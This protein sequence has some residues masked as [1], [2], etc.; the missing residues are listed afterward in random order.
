MVPKVC[1]ADPKGS[2][3][4]SHGIHGFISV[5]AILKFMYFVTN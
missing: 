1:V 4:G 2:A 3:T 5:V